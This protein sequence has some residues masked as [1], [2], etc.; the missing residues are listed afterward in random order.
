MEKHID[1]TYQQRRT[2]LGMG[3]L[4]SA[5]GLVAMLTMGL[6][7]TVR[8][9]LLIR[10]EYGALESVISGGLILAEVFIVA[11]A[12]GYVCSVMRS[13]WLKPKIEAAV[14]ANLDDFPTVDVLV[15]A[16]HEP[17]AVLERTL[18]A[19][20]GLRYP[21][22]NIWLLDDSS[23]PQYVNEA[24]ELAAEFGIRLYRREPRRGAKAGI[25]NDCLKQL[26]GEYVAFFD[27]DQC[28]MPFFLNRIIP[29]L[30][31]N[32]RLAFVQT[33][34]FYANV[35]NNRVAR[36]AGAQQAV[37]YE[38]IC[39]AKGASGAA[40][41]CGTN[42]VIRREALVGVG[43]MDESSITEDFATSIKLH[44]AGW[45]SLYYG[46]AYTMG[47]G[48][49]N[50]FAYFRQQYRW[51]RGTLGVGLRLLGL[52]LRK[53]HALSP[54]QWLD[55]GLSGTYYLIG[56]AFLILM[57][58][59]ILYVTLGIPSY[60]VRPEI[61]IAAFLPY[62]LFAAIVFIGGLRKRHY[63]LKQMVE[64]QLL[65]FLA[66]PIHMRASLSALLGIRSTFAVTPKAA[67]GRIPLGMLW[68]QVLIC[69]INYAAL[70]WGLC[71][72]FMEN[73]WAAGINSFWIGFHFLIFVSVFYFRDAVGTLAAV[74]DPA[75]LG[76]QTKV[77][78]S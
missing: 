51:A 7:L 9:V 10:S 20:V 72:C 39:E 69:F 78:V 8:S 70:I 49:E 11:H 26:E 65:V 3:A 42:V 50:L 43:G 34:Q 71:R 74:E 2:A 35:T 60:L 31:A 66:C 46:E 56:W 25:I 59:P 12:L 77:A 21:N 17:R 48:P 38:Y 68:P 67:A 22:K 53:P 76:T 45:K 27:A 75:Q 32:D 1:G 16:R 73:D 41:C 13:L 14:L 61:Y 47:V 5:F 19:L 58:C 30:V 6:Y 36:A 29:L 63:T 64:G 52:F 4:F 44:S 24:A 40:F 62:L 15:A 54:L 55:Y 18:S 23:D 33:P 28:P 57:L 37:F